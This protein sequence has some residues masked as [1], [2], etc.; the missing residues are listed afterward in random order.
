VQTLADDDEDLEENI[1]VALRVPETAVRASLVNV[2][3][4]DISPLHVGPVVNDLRAPQPGNVPTG[5]LAEGEDVYW[6]EVDDFPFV[7]DNVDL[8]QGVDPS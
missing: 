6:R 8:A 3:M 5:E 2:A 4:A 1:R 7:G